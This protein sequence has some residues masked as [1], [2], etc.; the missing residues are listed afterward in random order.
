[1]AEKERKP[2]SL[3]TFWGAFGSLILAVVIGAITLNS[4]VATNSAEISN[5]K[6]GQES[7]EADLVTMKATQADL[8]VTLALIKQEQQQTNKLLNQ[9]LEQQ[10]EYNKNIDFFY[11][12]NPNI[13]RPGRQKRG[14]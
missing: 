2:I 12:L 6:K 13:E 4:Q 8:V 7:M 3:L 5:L 11:D 14:N 10:K 1:M 9:I